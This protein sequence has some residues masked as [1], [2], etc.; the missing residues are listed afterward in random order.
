MA[1]FIR[2][3]ME[4]EIEKIQF[5]LEKSLGMKLTKTNTV[6]RILAEYKK[7]NR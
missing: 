6:R 4:D 3:D 7:R 2:G 5:Q 1:I